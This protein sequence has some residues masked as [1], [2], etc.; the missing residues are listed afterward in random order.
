MI[1]RGALTE[2]TNLYF[3]LI[4]FILASSCRVFRHRP[5]PSATVPPTTGPPT[6]KLVAPPSCIT[7]PDTATIHHSHQILNSYV[8]RGRPRLT[9]Q[10]AR[11]TTSNKERPTR[12]PHTTASMSE[13]SELAISSSSEAVRRT[14]SA[15]S[16]PYPCSDRFLPRYSP[17]EET[18]PVPSFHQDRCPVC[19][20]GCAGCRCGGV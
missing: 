9:R 1:S 18:E 20:G 16:L 11:I 4:I 6:V 2:Y 10:R 7:R 19:P 8:P 12:T 15:A 5:R 13:D 14:S 17:S 3:F